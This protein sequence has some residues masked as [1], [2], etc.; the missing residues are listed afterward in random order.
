[1]Q[2]LKQQFDGAV[3]YVQTAQ[4]SFKPSNDVK[5]EMYA[6]FKQATEGDVNGKKPGLTDFIGRAKYN[7]WEGLKGMSRDKAMQ[8]YIGKI[9]NLK[10]QHG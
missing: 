5:L 1:M 8:T 2:D 3:Q 4:G 10:N 9:D 6:L 7:A